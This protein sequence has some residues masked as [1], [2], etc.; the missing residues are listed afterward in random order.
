M[1]VL[2]CFVNQRLVDL[3]WFRVNDNWDKAATHM[4]IGNWVVMDLSGTILTVPL[5][6]LVL[7]CSEFPVNFQWTVRIVE[8]V[9]KTC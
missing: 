3:C 9:Y 8:S 6:E 4:R 2:W 7:V 5:V 1:H